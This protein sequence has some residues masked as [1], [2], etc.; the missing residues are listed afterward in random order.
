[1][2][3]W[4]CFVWSPPPPPTTSPP[5]KGGEGGYHHHHVESKSQRKVSLAAENSGNELPLVKKTLPRP[6]LLVEKGFCF[7][8]FSRGELQGEEEEA[9]GG[10]GYRGCGEVGEAE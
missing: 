3:S 2:I 5:K 1:M 8:L 10:T 9:V 6:L 7:F 4:K